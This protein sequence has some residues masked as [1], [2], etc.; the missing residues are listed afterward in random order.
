MAINLLK[1]QKID[2]T[3]G[4]SSLS[5]II[6]GLGWDA[7]N[8]QSS[9]IIGSIFSSQKRYDVDCDASVL[10]LNENKKLSSR[11]DMVYY[12]NLK[13]ACLSVVHS[14]DN[15]TGDGDGDDEQIVVE[16]KK[17][18][19]HIHSLVFFVTIYDC[20]NRKQDF[21]LINNAF[22]RIVDANTNKEIVRYNLSKDYAGKTAVLVGEIFRFEN[23]WRFSAIGEGTND[24][25]L[26]T[27]FTRYS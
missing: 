27:V 5:K 9:G 12:G 11:A 16:L 3:K 15:L 22:I 6:V 21:G 25:S 20:I 18:K 23:D 4:N 13:S 14:G 26:S 24:V 7:D 2:L 1:G 8:S 10:M 17:I 19:P